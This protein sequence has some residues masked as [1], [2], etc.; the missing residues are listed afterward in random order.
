MAMRNQIN[1]IPHSPEEEERMAAL[2]S[3]LS[4]S[5]IQDPEEAMDR[6]I[7]GLK[8]QY[9]PLETLPC[10][11][12]IVSAHNVCNKPGTKACAKCKLVSYCSPV[13]KKY[14]MLCLQI[15]F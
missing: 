10:A 12:V 6:L 13:S 3:M 9:P 14:A 7:P 5:N 11:K 2:A 8:A 4:S 1:A 15:R